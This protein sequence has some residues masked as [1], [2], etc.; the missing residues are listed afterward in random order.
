VIDGPTLLGD[1]LDAGV[2]V[3][4]VYVEARARDETWAAPLLERCAALGVRRLD[5]TDGTLAAATE[6]VTPQP[7]AAIGRQPAR[8]LRY[9]TSTA[10]GFVVV[11]AGVADPGNAGTIL[12]SAE[13]AGAKGV[14]VT[15]SSVDLHSPKVVR[16]SAG[17][18]FR[19]PVAE[20]DGTAVEL[21]AALA[22]AGFGVLGTVATGGQDYDQVDL[23][24]PTAIV[25]GNEARGLDPE[26]EDALTGRITI[27]M[28]GSTESLNV[29]M[30][31]TV[32]CFEAARQRRRR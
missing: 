21:V 24:G 23:T 10:A 28:A 32:V 20:A 18:I 15:A 16:A 8:P 9:F 29:A 11:L 30:A 22:G 27:P 7:I 5:L 14:I 6:T 31:A 13:A 3:D 26:V 12:R 17:S 19:V 1:A 4:A 2:E 25:L